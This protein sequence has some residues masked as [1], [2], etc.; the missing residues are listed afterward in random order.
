M[1]FSITETDVWPRLSGAIMDERAARHDG[2]LHV[3]TIDQLIRQ[4]SWIEA[5]DWV[6]AEARPK[7]HNKED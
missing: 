6:L 1:S 7:P 4:Q 3:T 5:L 2:L